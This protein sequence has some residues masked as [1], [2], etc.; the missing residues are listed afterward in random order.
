MLPNN[1]LNNAI[2]DIFIKFN[3]VC[4]LISRIA[5]GKKLSN[6]IFLQM[7]VYKDIGEKFRINTSLNVLVLSRFLICLKGLYTTNWVS[8]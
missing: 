5:F 1:Q 3:S 7:I 8:W 6:K 2:I 4:N